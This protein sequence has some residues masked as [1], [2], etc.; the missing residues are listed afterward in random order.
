MLYA[1][2]NRY[3]TE[4]GTRNL[5]EIAVFP[6]HCEICSKYTPDELRQL[7]STEKINQ[8][9]IHNLYAIKLEV[10]KVKQAIY[11]GDY[12]NMLSKQEHIQVSEMVKVMT[13]N[14]E[15]LKI[16]TPKFKERQ[17]FCLIKRINSDQKF[18][19]FMR[20]KEIQIKEKEN[21]CN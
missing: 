3:I 20:S 5:S 2:Q 13:E 4:D 18:N 6:C 8:L 9:A 1:K 10:D 11:E 14:A 21:S 16:S 19:H 12:G 17:F 7:E 15:F